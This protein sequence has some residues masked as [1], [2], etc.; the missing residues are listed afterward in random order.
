LLGANLRFQTLTEP[1][2]IFADG[3]L[4]PLFEEF[5]T[6]VELNNCTDRKARAALWASAGFKERFTADW[7]RRELRTF[8]RD[9][10]RM[11]IVR[12]PDPMLAGCTV[13]EVAASFGRGGTPMLIELLERYDD[14]LRWVAC[15]ANE[16]DAIRAR[17]MS[18]PHIFPGFTDAG[19][20][21]R[22]LAFF[23]GAVALLRQAVQSGFMSPQQAI[24]RVTLEPARWFNLPVGELRVGRRADLVL[25]QPSALRA[26]VPAPVEIEDPLLDGAARMVKRDSAE[27]VRSVFVAGTEFVRDGVPT[28]ALGRV[29]AGSVLQPTVQ[30][31]GHRAVLAR[32]RNRIDDLLVDHPFSEYWDV[33]VYKH[34]DRRNVAL[35]W[36]AVPTIHAGLCGLLVTWNPWWFGLILLSQVMGTTGHLL[37]ERSHIDVRDFVFSWR[38]S[39]CLHRMF[40]TVLRG[41]Y[42]REVGRVRGSFDAFSGVNP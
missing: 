31:R 18:H 3:P 26:P 19:A 32:H 37:F 41:G 34:Q 22:N 38:T 24:A 11:R 5:A 17:L 35:H 4:T 15:G 40:F 28:S 33:F 2:A 10:A 20:H 9:P 21:S 29:R 13:A 42:W 25:L 6:G 27:A 12:C 36:L 39:R 8:H 1:F 30:V 14:Q 23:D 16:R 7:E